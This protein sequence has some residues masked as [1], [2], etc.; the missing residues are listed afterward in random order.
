MVTTQL[1]LRHPG[2]DG[3]SAPLAGLHMVH[4]IN[5]LKHDYS[6]RVAIKYLLIAHI[7]TRCDYFNSSVIG[8]WEARH[9]LPLSYKQPCHQEESLSSN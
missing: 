7:S 3:S 8:Q 5:R 4:V 6:N 1:A 2:Q 9:M